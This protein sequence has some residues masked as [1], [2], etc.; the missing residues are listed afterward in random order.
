MPIALALSFGNWVM[1]E[2]IMWFWL[3][4][5]GVTAISAHYSLSKALSHADAMVVIPMDFLRL[6]IIMLVSLYFYNES[7]EWFLLLGASIM[8]FGNY[9]NLKHEIVNS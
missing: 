3:L 5:V 9:L 7:I 8:L 4:L 2:G 6:P 1:P